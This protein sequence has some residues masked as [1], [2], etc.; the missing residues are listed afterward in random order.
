MLSPPRGAY[1]DMTTHWDVGSWH[2]KGHW[3]K[4]RK[5]EQSKAAVNDTGSILIDPM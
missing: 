4:L 2:G 1:G 3:G 5:S